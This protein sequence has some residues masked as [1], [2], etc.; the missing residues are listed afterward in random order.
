MFTKFS[1]SS[2]NN[3]LILNATKCGMNDQS[4]KIF[5]IVEYLQIR[6]WEQIFV[7]GSINQLGMWNPE[8]ALEMSKDSSEE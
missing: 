5:F 4:V 8:N 7:V 6:K 1:V 2:L 3:E